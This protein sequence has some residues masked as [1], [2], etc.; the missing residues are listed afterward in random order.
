MVEELKNHIL[1]YLEMHSVEDLLDLVA[2][3]IEQSAIEG[4]DKDDQPITN[5]HTRQQAIALREF[6]CSL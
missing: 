2:N 5:P 6:I 3:S 4:Y 1:V